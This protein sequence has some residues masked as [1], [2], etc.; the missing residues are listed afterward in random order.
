MSQGKYSPT[1]HRMNIGGPFTFNSYGREPAPWDRD[2]YDEAT[3]LEGYDS[4]G[5]DYYGYSAFARDGDYAG[6]GCGKDRNGYTEMEYLSMTSEE[7]E[8][9]I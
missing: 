4:E 9:V 8:D 2:N 7:F 5:Y 6:C 1:I 3:M